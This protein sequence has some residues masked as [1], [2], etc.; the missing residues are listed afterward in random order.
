ML[1]LLIVRYILS[2][3]DHTV[4]ALVTFCLIYVSKDQGHLKI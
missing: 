1:R 2:T 3:F 4:C